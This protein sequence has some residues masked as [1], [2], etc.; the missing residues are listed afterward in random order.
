[1]SQQQNNKKKRSIWTIPVVLVALIGCGQ[2]IALAVLNPDFVKTFYEIFA[3]P[4]PP[5]LGSAGNAPIP[6]ET[7]AGGSAQAVTSTPVVQTETASPTPFAPTLCCLAGWDAFSTE[8][9]SSAPVP[10]GE[11]AN[12][13]IPELGISSDDCAFV[14]GVDEKRQRGVYGLSVPMPPNAE[15]KISI[16]VSTLLEGEVWLAFSKDADPQ[17]NS[18]VYA[19]TPDPGGVSVYLNDISAPNS[20]YSWN[21]MGQSLGWVKGQPW[22]YNFTVRFNGANVLTEVNDVRFASVA[23]P[24]ASRVFIGY[25]SKP[26]QT[27]FYLRARAEGLSISAIP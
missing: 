3:Q 11:C 1:M 8:G 20:R 17:D 13:K 7:V 12:I 23:A 5:L 27:G 16:V 19:M 9:L 15:I 21:P 25:R 4:T 2:A 10:Q 24:Y 14:F 18:L 6:E 22:R 26:Q